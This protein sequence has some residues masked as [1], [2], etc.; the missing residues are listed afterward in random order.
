MISCLTITYNRPEFHDFL[1]WNFNKQSC[2]NKELIV[3]DG[4]NENYEKIFKGHGIKYYHYPNE[5]SIPK[6]RNLAL[7]Y[8]NGNYLTWFAFAVFV[9]SH[10]IFIYITKILFNKFKSSLKQ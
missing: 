5:R 10:I 3:I 7:E 8:A 1:L 4:S 9:F 6:K 2:D